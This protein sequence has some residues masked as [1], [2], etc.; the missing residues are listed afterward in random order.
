[1]ESNIIDALHVATSNMTAS[2]TDDHF[3]PVAVPSSFLPSPFLLLILS[4]LLLV[5]YVALRLQNT[6]QSICAQLLDYCAFFY[7]TFLKPHSEV[8]GSGQQ[9]ALESFY[10]VQVACTKNGSLVAF[11]FNLTRAI[12]PTSMMRPVRGYFVVEKTC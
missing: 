2:I 7:T 9:A 12:R 1:M 5:L 10:K 6:F 4:A 3:P 8:D 11:L